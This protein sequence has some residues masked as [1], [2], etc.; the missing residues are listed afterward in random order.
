MLGTLVN[1]DELTE[2][3]YLREGS[4]PQ[5]SMLPTGERSY[6]K[7]LSDALWRFSTFFINFT[8]DAAIGSVIFGALL[9]FAWLVGLGKAVGM[10]REYTKYFE[11]AHFWVNYGVF[12]EVGISFLVRVMRGVFR[13]E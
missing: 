12:V 5:T 6:R 3:V 8:V 10:D 7:L 13:A 9:G 1:R 4:P 2:V 11:D